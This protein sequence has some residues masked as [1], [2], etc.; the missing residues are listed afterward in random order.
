MGNSTR[1]C[2]QFLIKSRERVRSEKAV[3]RGEVISKPGVLP[4][5]TPFSALHYRR[6][7]LRINECNRLISSTTVP[8][9]VKVIDLPTAPTSGFW[10]NKER[11]AREQRRRAPVRVGRGPQDGQ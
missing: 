1:A 2:Q 7:L 11:H 4:G 8:I 6:Q 9:P 10:Q 3:L 5:N